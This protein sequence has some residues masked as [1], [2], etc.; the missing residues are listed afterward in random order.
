MTSFRIDHIPSYVEDSLKGLFQQ[1]KKNSPVKTQAVSLSLEAAET[2]TPFSVIP[3]ELLELI[4]S[5]LTPP[6]LIK[7]GGVNREWL[8][9]SSYDRMW[10]GFVSRSMASSPRYKNH[11]KQEFAARERL[12]HGKFEDLFPIEGRNVSRFALPT[13]K[14]IVAE[15]IIDDDELF[16]KK[17][18][19]EVWS[20]NK[21]H[22]R[23]HTD[24]PCSTFTAGPKETFVLLSATRNPSSTNG[25]WLLRC[26]VW[27]K[28]KLS[29]SFSWGLNHPYEPFFTQVKLEN[30]RL[31]FKIHNCAIYIV[32]IWNAKVREVPLF[33]YFR[34]YHLLECRPGDDSL[35]VLDWGRVHAYSLNTFSLTHKISFDERWEDFFL[36]EDKIV[37]IKENNLVVAYAIE[38][39]KLEVKWFM[40]SRDSTQHA[41]VKPEEG[42]PYFGVYSH[43]RP[44]SK[45]KAPVLDIY[46]IDTGDLIA[47]VNNLP[48]YECPLRYEQIKISSSAIYY[49]CEG[50]LV[51]LAF[52]NLS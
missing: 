10:E 18:I 6:N 4:F 51:T 44:S 9:I 19:F 11:L 50:S 37:G 13:D 40:E 12:K 41:F 34:S 21:I 46:D 17:K 38:K 48:N 36:F 16:T 3:E 31:V 15:K 43:M 42:C 7:M 32:D 39:E 22:Y 47:T 52:K 27:K 8:R 1:T 30:D 45:I 20:K 14:V 35:T 25:R 26:K 24:N 2:S 33:Q 28:D 5:N 29:K 49:I 23:L